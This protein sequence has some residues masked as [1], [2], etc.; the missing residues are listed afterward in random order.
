[1]NQWS[2]ASFFSLSLSLSL[3]NFKSL[4]MHN[5]EDGYDEII[6][7]GDYKESGQIVDDW[8]YANF[9]TKVRAGVHVVAIVD[10]C[11]SGTAMDLPYVC[12]VGEN[13]IRRDDGFKIRATGVQLTPKK[14]DKTESKKKAAKKGKKMDQK[15]KKAP[16]KKKKEAAAEESEP[17]EAEEEEPDE[18]E[19]EE[20]EPEEVQ[21]EPKKK[22]KGLG[23]L[24]KKKK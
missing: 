20:A 11:H 2:K 6:I 14:T 16:K 8:I 13:E 5:K 21:V 4:L 1:M 10:C 19:P 23:G 12:N 22:R 3:S 7:P 18:V 15:E 9:V 17:F 24:F